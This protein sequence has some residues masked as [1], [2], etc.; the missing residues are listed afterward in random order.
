M[1]AAAAGLVAK[2]GGVEAVMGKEAMSL[3]GKDT[4]TAGK[5]AEFAVKND[6]SPGQI[7]DMCKQLFGQ[8]GGPTPGDYKDPVA[9]FETLFKDLMQLTAKAVAE[10]KAKE[11]NAAPPKHNHKPEQSHSKSKKRKNNSPFK[12]PSLKPKGSE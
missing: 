12:I 7:N 3:F 6:I 8:T 1:G 4:A 10:P 5:I 2:A 9:A 11:N